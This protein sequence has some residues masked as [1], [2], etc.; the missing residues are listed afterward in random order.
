M[1][2]QQKQRNCV[3]ES[4]QFPLN[5]MATLTSHNKAQLQKKKKET[6]KHNKY[7]K[8]FLSLLLWMVCFYDLSNYCMAPIQLLDFQSYISKCIYTIII[9]FHFHLLGICV[10]VAYS[11][12]YGIPRQMPQRVQFH[13]LRQLLA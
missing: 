2:L 12:A 10:P 4:F 6:E 5:R 11:G 13:C 9:L 3:F 1:E 7:K 8:S